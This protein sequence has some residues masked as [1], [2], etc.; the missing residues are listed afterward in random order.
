M[1]ILLF[2]QFFVLDSEPGGTRHVFLCHFFQKMGAQVRV[3]AGSTN[4]MTGKS[5][6]PLF[7]PWK[8]EVVD[9]I[10]ITW[11]YAYPGMKQGILGRLL[12]YFSF[13]FFAFPFVLKEKCDV[14]IAT[15][16]PPTVIFLGW[17]FHWIKRKPWVLEVR[18]LWPEMLADLGLKM[19]WGYGLFVSVM[20]FFYTHASF[21]VP[22]TPGLGT[23][24]LQK[25]VLSER[26]QV[27]PNGIDPIFLSPP[28]QEAFSVLP[29]KEKFL[30]LHLGT[31]S[32]SHSLEPLIKAAE[33]FK[34]DPRLEFWFVGDG[35]G[36]KRLEEMAQDLPN[37]RFLNP[38]PRKAVPAL[39][40][41]ADLCIL[42]YEPIPS[43]SSI[44]PNRFFDYL[45]SGKPVIICLQKGDASEI[46][47]KAG[48]GIRLDPGDVPLLRKT[49]LYFLEHPEEGKKMGESGRAY[50]LQHYLRENLARDYFQ[51][52][53]KLCS[54]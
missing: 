51:I 41:L 35:S 1:K 34:E 20:N 16:P 50:V 3:I 4:Y 18:D 53:S 5:K 9:G 22:L 48:G 17:L 13:F 32:F 47:E 44:L 36:R 28:N 27:I 7:R 45:V 10:H 11:V 49:I 46:L 43:F 8:N 31:I 19:G 6:L 12:C 14:V 37:V 52:L 54:T 23:T 42:S 33:S 39:L 2:H 38:I 29:K 25:G 40:S 26:L 15:T 30:V 24:L 21:V